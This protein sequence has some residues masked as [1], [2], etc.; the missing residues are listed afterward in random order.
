MWGKMWGKIKVVKIKYPQNQMIKRVL[1]T[2][3]GT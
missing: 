3:S 1:S 2:R